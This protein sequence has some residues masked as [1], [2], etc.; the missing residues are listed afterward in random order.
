[1]RTRLAIRIKR[2]DELVKLSDRPV[3]SRRSVHDALATADVAA[4]VRSFDVF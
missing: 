3:D 1:M 4:A 2:K